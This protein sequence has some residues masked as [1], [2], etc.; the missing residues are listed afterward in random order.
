MKTRKRFKKY[1]DRCG[2]L[3]RPTGRSARLCDACKE[4]SMIERNK[5]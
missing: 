3:F 5:K 4:K 2:E 1:C